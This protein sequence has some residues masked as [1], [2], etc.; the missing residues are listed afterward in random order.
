MKRVLSL[1]AVFAVLLVM[2]FIAPAGAQLIYSAPGPSGLFAGV[3]AG[4]TTLTN[5]D[6]TGIGY[7][8][9]SSLTS[10]FWN[11][12]LGSMSLK[13]VTSG[14]SNTGIGMWALTNM[15]GGARN[16]AV[17]Q[18]AMGGSADSC[19]N[20]ALG[21]NSL[22]TLHTGG[23]SYNTAAGF[24][25]MASLYE[26]KGNTAVG[27]YAGEPMSDGNNN[28]FIGYVS[29]P[30]SNGLSNATA[31]GY[32]AQVGASNSLVLGG[33]GSYAVKVGI[34]TTTPTQALDV[35]GNTIRV[36][37]SRTPSSSS[38][39][40]AQ[41]EIAWDGSYIYVC[42]AANTWMRSALSSF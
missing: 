14:V 41:G 39:T 40:C 29:G 31:I 16:T 22:T 24:Q 4:N 32:N 42:V 21:Y 35:N 38:D 19:N 23:D 3:N 18:G 6:N 9:L 5:G 11:T 8:S 10:G 13:S 30:T 37:Q 34:G 26:G 17:G 2:G 20:V 15:Q 7:Y 33:T 25:A 27:G 28:T 1:A 12:G 36:R